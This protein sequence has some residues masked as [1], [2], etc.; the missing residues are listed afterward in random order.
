M[1]NLI[2]SIE[3]ELKELNEKIEDLSD[4]IKVN[5]NE[6]EPLLQ[7]Q[8]FQMLQYKDAINQRLNKLK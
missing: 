8:M 7:M 3:K 1:E 4:Y 2:K 5:E 6:E